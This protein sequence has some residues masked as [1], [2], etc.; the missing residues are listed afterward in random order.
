MALSESIVVPGAA[1][2]L[3]HLHEDA[4]GQVPSQH[5]PCRSIALVHDDDT[6]Q[7][8]EAGWRARQNSGS[9]RGQAR[10]RADDQANH[11]TCC[12]GHREKQNYPDD[13]ERSAGGK[14][15]PC[16][17]K[18]K[19]TELRSMSRGGTPHSAIDSKPPRL[20][21]SPGWLYEARRGD[22][23]RAFPEEA[24]HSRNAREIRRSLPVLIP[25]PDLV[26][27]GCGAGAIGVSA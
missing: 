11:G 17:R 21:A 25:V 22:P 23:R 16:N 5:C 15:A 18:G 3:Q 19:S 27:R 24:A 6:R 4:G 26:G 14:K 7:K 20:P 9:R 10:T 2:S 8:P 12:N 13:A 1:V